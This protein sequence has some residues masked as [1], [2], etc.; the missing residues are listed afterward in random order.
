[1]TPLNDRKLLEEMREA[2]Y[3]LYRDSLFRREGVE[4]KSKPLSPETIEK[5]RSLGYIE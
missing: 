3:A 5:L 4:S 1:V 2:L